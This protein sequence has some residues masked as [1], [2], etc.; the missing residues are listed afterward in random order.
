MRYGERL[1][2]TGFFYLAISVKSQ[3]NK[4]Q[5]GLSYHLH[6]RET[7]APASSEHSQSMTFGL[8][9]VDRLVS[10]PLVFI[11]QKMNDR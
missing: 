10:Y 1:G 2:A 4:D 5:S 11:Y 9:L 3:W 6:Y 8:V 7:C